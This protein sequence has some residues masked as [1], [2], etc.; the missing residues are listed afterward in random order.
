[1][2][3]VCMASS[4]EIQHR[5]GRAE[6]DQN[7]YS[8]GMSDSTDDYHIHIKKYFLRKDTLP[9]KGEGILIKYVHVHVPRLCPRG[10]QTKL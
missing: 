1:M 7:H 4:T 6:T 2:Q 9:G 3:Q 5:N 10:K 8:V